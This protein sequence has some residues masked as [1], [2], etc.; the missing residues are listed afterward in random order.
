MSLEALLQQL[1]S[2]ASPRTLRLHPFHALHITIELFS[3]LQMLESRG[4]L[5]PLAVAQNYDVI[6]S[7]ALPAYAAAL[8]DYMSLEKLPNQHIIRYERLFLGGDGTLMLLGIDSNGWLRRL[9]N[10]FWEVHGGIPFARA[11]DSPMD[12]V[13]TSLGR[14]MPTSDWSAMAA[15][16]SE[17]EALQEAC[18]RYNDLPCC[19]KIHVYPRLDD[20][21]RF[22]HCA[23]MFLERLHEST[24]L[25][26][27][28]DGKLCK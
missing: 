27:F 15:S 10:V 4:M 26:Q 7:Q 12:I 22:V 21:V 5:A 1:A 6:R 2:C 25:L 8:A 24:P 17:Y 9:R 16:K 14:L 28:C 18:R 23:S 19:D 3:N 11:R 13:H 20:S